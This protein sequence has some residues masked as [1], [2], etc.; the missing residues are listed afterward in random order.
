MALPLIPLIKILALGSLK[1]VF[2]LFGAVFFPVLSLRFI[3][4]GASG[5][6]QPTLDWLETNGRLDPERHVAVIE[7]L[8][9]LGKIEFTRAEARHLL[10]K[11]VGKTI[12][13]M[14]SAI[15]SLPATIVRLVK[16]LFNR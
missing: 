13:G 2:L 12:H 9:A 4:T 8:N 14:V 3:L 15:V 5:M 10:F 16:Q 11:L 7:D 6:L 1:I